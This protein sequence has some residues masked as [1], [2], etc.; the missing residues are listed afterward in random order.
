MRLMNLLLPHLDG[1]TTVL[2]A[3]GGGLDIKPYLHLPDGVK[4]RPDDGESPIGN[5]TLMLLSYGPEPGLHGDPEDCRRLLG[6]MRPGGRGLLVFGYRS[7]ELP[8]HRL[9]DDLV[10]NRCQVLRATSLDYLHLHGGA[11][12]AHARELL[13]PYDDASGSPL[14]DGTAANA[15][16]MS[17]E[18][19]L[20]D[21]V[22]RALRVRLLDLEAAREADAQTLEAARDQQTRLAET[23][24][25]RDRLAAALSQARKRLG[26]LEARVEMLQ[27][28]ASLRVGQALVAAARDPVRGAARLP[29]DLYGLWRGRRRGAA[30]GTAPVTGTDRRYAAVDGHDAGLHLAH[31]AVAVGPRDRLVIAGVLR[32]GTAADLAVDA[33]VNRPLPHDGRLMVE[34]TDPDVLVVQL[35][36]CAEGPWA[37]TGTGTAPDLDRRLAQVLAAARALGRPSVLWLDAEI[38]AAPGLTRFPWDAVLEADAG[39]QPA[40]LDPGALGSEELRRIFVSRATRVRLAALAG[41][42]GLTDAADP[43]DARRVAVLARPRGMPE[44]RV[45]V[46][47]VLAQLHRPAE[48]V[49]PVPGRELAELTAS[50]VTVR[51]VDEGP[52]TPWVADWADLSADRPATHLLDLMCGQ[53]CSGADA[54]GFAGPGTDGYAFVPALEP[55]LVRRSLM[56]SGV[57]PGEWARRGQRLFAIPRGETP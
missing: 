54:V 40:R 56:N 30:S 26:V 4:L 43:L 20:A 47:Q 22:S 36:A 28:S 45:L 9:L 42:A 29:R 24:R 39:V 32:P 38:S 10:R 6:R 49:V 46:R 27:G 57:P 12:L 41:A 51:T 19:V 55:A 17:D 53:E 5:G 44:V 50:G 8:Y 21:F 37:H 18:Y 11:V 7:A 33:V 16:R 13:P 48:V 34:R 25:E 23:V 35:T 14:P 15:L 3:T 2:D 31:R 52:T 1:V